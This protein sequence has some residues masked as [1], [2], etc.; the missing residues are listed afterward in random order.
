MLEINCR[1]CENL[2]NCV[3]G[4]RVYGSDAQKA[5]KACAADRFMNYKTKAKPCQ[6]VVALTNPKL[7]ALLELM[8]A[9]P[10]L[11]VVA[12]VD[13]EIVA[14]DGYGRWLGSWGCAYEDTY[15][16]GE[17]R[18]YFYDEDDPNAIEEVLAEVKGWDWYESATD[19]E[20]LA[21]YRA[22]PWIKC[23]VVNIDL[24]EA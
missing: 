15:Y 18:V 19:E 4:C 17:E 13:S 16:K 7:A 3:D 24:P 6:N 20:V 10:H 12:M 14:D 2:I 23:I 21:A 1:K 8:K 22:L 11:P 5:T 9:K